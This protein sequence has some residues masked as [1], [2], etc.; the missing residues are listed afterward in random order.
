VSGFWSGVA[1]YTIW[2]LFPIYWR[3]F[4]HVPA[5]QVLGHRVVWSFIVLALVV[6]GARRQ[7]KPMLSG[8]TGRVVGLYAMAGVLIGVNWFLY[9][10]AVNAGFIVETSLG[11][12][13]TPLVNVLLGVLVFRER[14]RPAQWLAVALA[15]AGVV[16]LT[17]AY[18][19]LPWIAFGLAMSFGT[20]GL[21]KK[22][23][24]LGPL[25]GLTLETAMLCP[26]ALVY[27]L[28]LHRAGEGA[29]LRTGATADMLMIGGGLVTIVPLLLFAS[30]VR[31]VPLTV[32]GILQYIGPTLQFFL[33]VFV[34]REPFSRTQLIG[35]AIVW[36]A[37]IIFAVDSLRARRFAA[38]TMPALDEGTA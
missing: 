3:L 10:F 2:G 38:Q 33:G 32:I 6:A 19:S 9:V 28:V 23:A 31:S 24:P 12:Y 18:G 36:T 34:F 30:A 29:F 26:A 8:L 16:H 1:A 11:Y 7:G 27:L 25:E 13:I 37:L 15:A 20:Y 21:V 17:L 35:F 4:R 14:L 5:I 22:K